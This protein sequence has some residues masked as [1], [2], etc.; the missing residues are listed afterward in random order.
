MSKPVNSVS[1]IRHKYAGERE[2]DCREE[3][4]I[5][6]KGKH[7]AWTGQSLKRGER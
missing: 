3:K 2:K 6:R 5:L 4:F 1:E 7:K